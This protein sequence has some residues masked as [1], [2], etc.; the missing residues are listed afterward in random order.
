MTSSSESKISGSALRIAGKGVWQGYGRVGR[1]W[2]EH[3]D[4]DHHFSLRKSE[5][6]GQEEKEKKERRRKERGR[7]VHIIPQSIKLD[8]VSRSRSAEVGGGTN[9]NGKRGLSRCQ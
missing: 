8:P 9:E 5:R 2:E 3:K 7:L 1:G 6:R 4:D